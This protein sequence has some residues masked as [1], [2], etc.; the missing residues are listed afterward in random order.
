MRQR[1]SSGR[2]SQGVLRPTFESILRVSLLCRVRLARL[3][4]A[5]VIFI[6]PLITFGPTRV[7]Q[8]IRLS[9]IQSHG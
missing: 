1:T 4:L 3:L 2:I 7:Q 6:V 5:V 9:G 8:S